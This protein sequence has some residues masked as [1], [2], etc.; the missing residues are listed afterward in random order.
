M[1]LSLTLEQTLFISLS[2]L[3]LCEF[4]VCVCMYR[5]AFTQILYFHPFSLPIL[6]C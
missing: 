1:Y 4:D 2:P 5:P 3:V 6:P